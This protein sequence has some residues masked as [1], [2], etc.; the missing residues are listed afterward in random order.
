MDIL[1][2]MD[3]CLRGLA[4]PSQASGRALSQSHGTQARSPQAWE[5][6]EARCSCEH[7]R[8]MRAAH[9]RSMSQVRKLR[10]R[11]VK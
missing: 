1:E 9:Y 2:P 10:L 3:H 6:S 11:E 5:V 8:T 7:V 4:H